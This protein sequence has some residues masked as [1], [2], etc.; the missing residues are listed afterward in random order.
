MKIKIDFLL[1]NDRVKE[2]YKNNKFWN[3]YCRPT[4]VDYFQELRGKRNFL[5]KALSKT[6]IGNGGGYLVRQDIADE[7]I[8]YFNI[9]PVHPMCRCEVII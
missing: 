1:V 8:K 5:T 2:Y 3:K 7:I 9:L 4:V 6:T